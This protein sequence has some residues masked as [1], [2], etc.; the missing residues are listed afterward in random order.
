[1][2][3]YP[4][5]AGHVTASHL[6]PSQ[7]IE[8]I[9]RGVEAEQ[10]R[11]Y[12]NQWLFN[13]MR[14]QGG[15][16]MEVEDNEYQVV[17]GAIGCNN[18]LIPIKLQ[19]FNSLPNRIDD[20]YYAK[21]HGLTLDFSS[22]VQWPSPTLLTEQQSQNQITE[23]L[24]RD[25]GFSFLLRD[26]SFGPYVVT[27]RPTPKQP[28]HEP[29]MVQGGY[30]CEKFTSWVVGRLEVER[31]TLATPLIK[32]GVT[33]P[34][35]VLKKDAVEY[36]VELKTPRTELREFLS[37]SFYTTNYRDGRTIVQE[38]N[39]RAALTPRHMEIIFMFDLR[40]SGQSVENAMADLRNSITH[41]SHR[42]DWWSQNIR[43]VIFITN[44]GVGSHATFS[45]RYTMDQ[46]LD[47]KTDT[48]S[49]SEQKFITSFLTRQTK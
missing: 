23:Y 48:T 46:V 20:D 7:I 4:C 27:E 35:F 49:K 32:G 14:G 28:V 13:K 12:D 29:G 38:M 19:S 16:H 31:T 18:G 41:N 37:E 44:S 22:D 8:I 17:C 43:G 39:Q 47:K 45:M 25:G 3:F 34:D 26:G 24:S 5:K 42:K 30:L 36:S 9:S 21:K 40:N 6:S 1:M 10:H 11:N 15:H 2:Y 33:F